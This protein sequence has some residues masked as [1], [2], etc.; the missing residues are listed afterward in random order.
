MT[1][2]EIRPDLAD[3]LREKAEREN[4]SVDDVLE[5]LL[6]DRYASDESE[7]RIP[8]H[9]RPMFYRRARRYWKEVGDTERLASSWTNSSGYS[10]GKASR[11]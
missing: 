10:I 11:A 7:N 8:L 3:K 9:M 2:L 1:T 6:T 4:R 5:S